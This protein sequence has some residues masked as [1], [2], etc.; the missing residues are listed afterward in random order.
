M[1]N[2]KSGNKKVGWIRLTA[3]LMAVGLIAAACGDSGGDT[4]PAATTAA[5]ATTAAAPAAAALKIALVAPSASDDLAFTQSMVDAI[6]ALNEDVELSVTDGTFVIEEAAAAI[7]EYAKAG[8]D[9][10]VAHGTQFGA[11]LAE[12]APD[13][14]DTTFLWGTST[15]TQGLANVFAYSPNAAEGGYVNGVVA[16]GNLRQ[17]V[18]RCGRPDRSR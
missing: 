18:D 7:R 15:D 8:N 17:W 16:A 12:I 4:A 1:L 14:P 5:P 6:G 2:R 10:V 13:F 3:L 11:S 9:I